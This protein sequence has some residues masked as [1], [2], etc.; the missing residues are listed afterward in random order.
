[1]SVGVSVGLFVVVLVGE[2]VGWS[3][4]VPLGVPVG[5]L[6]A[7]FDELVG[8]ADGFAV[9]RAEAVATADGTSRLDSEPVEQPASRQAAANSPSVVRRTDNCIENPPKNK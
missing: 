5:V 4:G 6:V 7:R 2:A 8:I 1:A 3:E 9:A